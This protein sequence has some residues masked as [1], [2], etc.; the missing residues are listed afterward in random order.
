MSGLRLVLVVLATALALTWPALLLSGA[1]LIFSDTFDFLAMDLG[2]ER[3]IRP[4]GY[5]WFAG[6]L[7]RVFGS[8][9]PV[10]AT[11]AL[12]TAALAHTV[13]RAVLPELR[14]REH[15]AAGFGLAV[16]TTAPWAASYVMPDALTAPS[17]LALFLVPATGTTH[18][19]GAAA[20]AA[21]PLTVYGHV[22]A[23]PLAALAS[24][25]DT[26]TVTFTY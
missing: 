22:T 3:Y 4:R 11:Q 12:L 26:I 24:D 2:S 14:M 5:G 19:P 25:A 9:W 17:L 7:A 18:G 13:L 1:P 23:S 6:S 16:L 15:I 10:V 8:L 21:Q 20:S